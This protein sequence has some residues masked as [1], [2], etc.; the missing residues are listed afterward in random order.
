[1]QN[2]L[3][4]T[5]NITQIDRGSLDNNEFWLIEIKLAYLASF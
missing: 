2:Y 5:S 3:T 4:D 1:M